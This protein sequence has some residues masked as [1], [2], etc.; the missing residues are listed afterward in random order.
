MQIVN[1]G[2]IVTRICERDS[3]SDRRDE[4]LGSTNRHTNKQ[5]KSGYQTD[6][7]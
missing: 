1:K 7:V 3:G 5:E 6:R 4:G 2:R